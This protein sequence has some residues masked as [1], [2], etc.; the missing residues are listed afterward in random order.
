[1]RGPLLFLL[2]IPALIALGHDI[3]LFYIQHLNPGIFSIDLLLEKFKFSALGFIWTTYAVDSYKAVV[4]ATASDTWVII[5]QLLTIKAFHLS[6]GFAGAFIMLFF[7][8]KQFGIGPFAGE[9]AGSS[10]PKKRKKPESFRGGGKSKKMQ[11]KR[12]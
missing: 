1:M 5:D 2:L 10:S 7:I 12:K 6:L 9:N 4:E 3:Y 8:L 11:Y